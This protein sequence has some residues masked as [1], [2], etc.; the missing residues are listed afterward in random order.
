MYLACC[1]A[2]GLGRL[3]LEHDRGP[4]APVALL[5]DRASDERWRVREAV[6]MALQRISDRATEHL[7]GLDPDVRWLVR[8]NLT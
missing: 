8:Q 7:H 6:A 1:G 5:R 2:A 3:A 4:P